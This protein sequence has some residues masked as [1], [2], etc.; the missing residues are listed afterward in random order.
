[1]K[2]IFLF[3]FVASIL[4]G[5][6]KTYIPER[7]YL[8]LDMLYEEQ[9]E[10]YPDMILPATLASMIEKESCITLKH[11]K[12]WNPKVEFKTRWKHNNLR[13]EHGGGVSMITRAWN[14]QGK[15]RFDTLA[16][17]KRKYPKY[18][19][20]LNWKNL[21]AK[22]RLQFRAMTLLLRDNEEGLPPYIKG[23]NREVM[24]VVAYNGG[25]GGL[26]RELNMCSLRKNCDPSLWFD[27]VERTCGKSKK[28]LYGK[29]S[30]CQINRDY[31]R[32]IYLVKLAKYFR[33]YKES[34]RE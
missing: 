12:C 24:A 6:E 26:K 13:R 10:F 5:N 28:I 20:D 31:P 14:K 27:N 8:Y 29:R 34:E 1:M 4:V 15:L 21:S 32:S 17:L 19:N 9:K 16:R 2:I 23:I 11:S 33:E 7:A 22:P 3:F 25:L 30:A 18:L